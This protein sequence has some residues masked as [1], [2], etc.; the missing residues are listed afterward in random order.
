M[1]RLQKH[2]WLLYTRTLHVPYKLFHIALSLAKQK[3]RRIPSQMKS[4]SAN[5]P[6]FPVV[7]VLYN[8]H[9]TSRLNTYSV[10]PPDEMRS[11]IDKVAVAL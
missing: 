4:A 1:C 9:I 2:L 10:E 3:A 7:E 11:M 5:R 8:L 6:A